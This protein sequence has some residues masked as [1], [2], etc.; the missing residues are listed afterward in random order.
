MDFSDVHWID[1]QA[2]KFAR[3]LIFQNVDVSYPHRKQIRM[4]EQ[5]A[6]F[7]LDIFYSPTQ[8]VM[9]I[10]GQKCENAFF[11]IEHSHI[12]TTCKKINRY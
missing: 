5:R 7:F 1:I 3:Y 10:T 11:C 8:N 9:Q 12:K 6:Y 2:R 4:Y